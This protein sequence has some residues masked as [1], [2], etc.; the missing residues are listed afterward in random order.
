MAARK[1][2]GELPPSANG[3]A[4]KPFTLNIADAELARMNTLLQLSTVAAANYE[5]TYADRSNQFGVTREWLVAAKD[6]W[7]KGFDWR[8]R[9]DLVNSFPNFKTAI[10]VPVNGS[11]ST[12][13]SSSSSSI[14]IHFTALFSSNPRA[15][16]IVLLHGW[17]GSFFEFLPMLNL[18]REKYPD[19]DEL[20]YHIVVPSLPGYGLSDPPPARRNFTVDDATW[21][22]DHLMTK[23]L[24]FD[25]YVAQGGDVG[26][27]VAHFLGLGYPACR[28]V[29]LN[30]PSVPPPPDFDAD[31]GALDDA[32]EEGLRRNA[33]FAMTGASHAIWHAVRPATAGLVVMASPLAMLAWLGEKFLY[34]TDPALTYSVQ[35]MDEAIAESALYY[36]TGCAS[37]SLYPY[38]DLMSRGQDPTAALSSVIAAPKILG[39]SWFRHELV[40]APKAWLAKIGNLVFFK[41]HDKG[42]HFAALEQPAALL[43]DVEEFAS[44]LVLKS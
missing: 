18:L 27:Y 25:A 15:T 16:P 3:E 42:G 32:D 7:E 31:G 19:D 29:H 1:Q 35:L 40:M 44:K 12:S 41:R 43:E 37:T 9:E 23:A 6:R 4:I 24:G 30:F 5:N 14:N 39:Y 22:T 2:Y 11:P 21:M 13:S 28:G 20:P 33:A 36:L 26:A 34:W 8:K 38:R 10:P 17:P